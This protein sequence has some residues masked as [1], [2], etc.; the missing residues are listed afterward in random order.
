MRVEKSSPSLKR[1]VGGGG[2]AP[3]QMIGLGPEQSNERGKGLQ[4]QTAAEIGW[5]VGWSLAYPSDVMGG[6]LLNH[7]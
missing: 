4:G 6:E 5:G 7:L 1:G 2:S 3:S